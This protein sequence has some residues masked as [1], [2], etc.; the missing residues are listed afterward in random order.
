MGPTWSYLFGPFPEFLGGEKIFFLT[1]II[2]VVFIIAIVFIII[3]M[4]YNSNSNNTDNNKTVIVIKK[5]V[6][7]VNKVKPQWKVHG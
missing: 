3:I 4:N 7:K 5:K 2:S 1:N 6:N